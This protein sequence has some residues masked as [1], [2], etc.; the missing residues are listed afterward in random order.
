L[1]ESSTIP[2]PETFV[3]LDKQHQLHPFTMLSDHQKNGPI[4]MVRG[5]GT[6][7]TDHLGREYLDAF[8]G[9]W[10]VNIGYG[11][12]EIAEAVSKQILQ[13]NYFHSFLAMANE[14]SIA[15]AERLKRLMPQSLDRVFFG[16]SGSDAN[17][18]NIKI[19][20]LYNNL[21][22]QPKKKKLIAR[23]SGYHGVT[24][25]TA[26]LSGLPNLHG[27]FDV[28]L[29][30][31]RFFHV[32]TPHHYRFAKEGMTE[33]EFSS[34]LAEE[35]EQTIL[36]EGPETVAAFVAEPVMG[37]GGVFVPPEGYFEAIVPVLRKY[38]VLLIA[39]EVICGFGR[40]GKWSGSEAFHLQ[41]D[42]MTMAK[43]LTSAYVPLSASMISRE[44]WNVLESSPTPFGHGYTYSAHPVAAAAAIANLD[45]FDRE[46]LIDRA[47]EMGRILQ[48][49]LREELLDHPLVGQIRG[50]GM[51]AG[52]ELVADK[53]TKQS[54][55]PKL[56]VQVMVYKEMMRRG[57]LV[58]PIPN[59]I[60]VSPPLVFTPSDIET[61]V[62]ALK[63]SLDAT[64]SALPA[65]T[66]A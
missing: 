16:L 59:T 19:V 15:L 51:V 54:F 56:A 26:S 10:C 39:D 20:W 8:A 14:P 47:A 21:R 49:R 44:I 41:P 43:G 55:D 27:G 11:R 24:V 5:K 28:P 63:E 52:I 23:R 36:R 29:D 33:L 37:A 45:V 53:Q 18:T 61:L 3:S 35:L 30:I 2:S 4:V 25:A 38:D 9:L 17:D 64:L 22:G 48:S 42:L 7:L 50:V 12:E 66:I 60:A 62:G 40:L 57:V 1:N 13:L 58:R 6:K 34:Y 65:T 32:T 31:D 46:N